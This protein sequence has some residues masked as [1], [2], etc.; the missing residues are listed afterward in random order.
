MQNNIINFNYNNNEVRTQ[1]LNNEPYFCLKDT[2]KVLHIKNHKDTLNRLD[3]DGV[4]LTDLIDRLGRQQQVYF[5]NEP[6]LYR[7]IFRSDKPEAKH[8]QDW[9]F[10][11]V[12]PTLRKTGTYT[13]N[14]NKEKNKQHNTNI[15]I[16]NFPLPIFSR[17]NIRYQYIDNIPYF[18]YTDIFEILDITNYNELIYKLSI[19]L[20]PLYLTEEDKRYN[21]M[22]SLGLNIGQILEIIHHINNTRCILFEKFLLSDENIEKLSCKNLESYLA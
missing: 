14:N 5:I 1:L 3:R 16:L 20:K 2:C 8:F 10:N 15:N 12:L 13:I 7:V 6:N 21:N 18:I 17:T 22:F 19:I 4:V 11:E 9:V